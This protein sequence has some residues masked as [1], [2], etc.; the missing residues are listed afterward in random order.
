MKIVSPIHSRFFNGF[1]RLVLKEGDL[2]PADVDWDGN[3]TPWVFNT[4]KGKRFAGLP[5]VDVEID[6]L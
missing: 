5:D 6:E 4:D 1:H 2:L 3:P